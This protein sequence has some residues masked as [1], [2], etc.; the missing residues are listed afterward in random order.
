MLNYNRKT[1][2]YI[3][4]GIFCLIILAGLHYLTSNSSSNEF[5][6]NLAINADGNIDLKNEKNDLSS[7]FKKI[8]SLTKKYYEDSVREDQQ[9]NIILSDKV[10][11][12]EY[13]HIF[14]EGNTTSN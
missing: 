3:S 10:N 13:N 8:D 12:E 11:I 5:D 2:I 4:L 14:D 6:N 1:I 9:K 7:N